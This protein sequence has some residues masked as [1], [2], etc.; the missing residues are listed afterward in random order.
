MFQEVILPV[1][2]SPTYTEDWEKLSALDGWKLVARQP[3]NKFVVVEPVNDQLAITV[4]DLFE[5]FR[6]S[7][8]CR[9]RRKSLLQGRLGG[10]SWQ[11]SAVWGRILQC[12]R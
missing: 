5:I 2:G 10:Y 8:P 4:A 7:L 9:T 1:V 11:S 6:P 3:P 12:T